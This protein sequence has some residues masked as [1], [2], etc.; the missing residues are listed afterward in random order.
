MC[1]YTIF[2]IDESRGACPV[3]P[4]PASPSS[5]LQ[6]FS[7]KSARVGGRRPQRVGARQQEILEL[8]LF[9]SKNVTT[10]WLRKQHLD[11]QRDKTRLPGFCAILYIH[12]ANVLYAISWL[13]FRSSKV[14]LTEVR[15]LEYSCEREGVRIWKSIWHYTEV[16]H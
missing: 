15:A 1:G 12:E 9:M 3:H 6:T 5:F 7:P 10:E 4:P 14:I 13:A 8:S 2:I 11:L 16:C